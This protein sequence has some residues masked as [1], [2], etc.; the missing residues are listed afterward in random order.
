MRDSEPACFN[1]ECDYY[2][3]QVKQGIP[4]FETL[5]ESEHE[6]YRQRVDHTRHLCRHSNRRGENI[7]FCEKCIIPI[8][9]LEG[10]YEK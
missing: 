8:K 6:Y 4:F 5:E 10:T 7:Y 3:R 1:P 2:D 9:V